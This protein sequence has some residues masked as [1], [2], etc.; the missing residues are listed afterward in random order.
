MGVYKGALLQKFYQDCLTERLYCNIVIQVDNIEFHGHRFLLGTASSYFSRMFRSKFA[1]S[2]SLKVIV[3]GPVAQKIYPETMQKVFNFIYTEHIFLTNENIDSV[4]HAAE[5]LDV[6]QL[7]HV[8][9][10]YLTESLSL[11]TWMSTF[12]MAKSLNI[13]TLISA[14]INAFPR[15][16]VKAEFS[17]DVLNLP[18]GDIKDILQ[19]HHDNRNYYQVHAAITSWMATDRQEQLQI[20]PDL[21]GDI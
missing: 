13:K 10:N 16:C 12:N 5:F 6:E 18:P 2:K 11:G 1:D 15:F 7:K 9:V 20:H 19:Y 3:Q 4:L 17:T 21:F 14:C 8:C